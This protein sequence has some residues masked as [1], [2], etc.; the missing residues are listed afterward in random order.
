[1]IKRPATD[2]DNINIGTIL[3]VYESDQHTLKEIQILPEFQNQG[4]GTELIRSEIIL[5]K[6][7]KPANSVTI[8][9]HQPR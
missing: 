1:M 2:K 5:A 4:I 7:A 6:K 8:I 3:M 9:K